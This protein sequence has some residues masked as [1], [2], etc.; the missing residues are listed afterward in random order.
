MPS[1]KQDITAVIERPRRPTFS[2]LSFTS[3]AYLP[4]FCS[5][6]VLPSVRSHYIWPKLLS[7]HSYIISISNN[8][9][10]S[11]PFSPYSYLL[12]PHYTP[13]ISQCLHLQV[14]RMFTMILITFFGQLNQKRWGLSG[15]ILR[16]YYSR[17]AC[18]HACGAVPRTGVDQN[19]E[20]EKE[21]QKHRRCHFLM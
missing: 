2:S 14:K 17:H 15:I 13:V 3:P 8:K 4:S 5:S 18:R 7:T 11:S 1:M 6:F 9:N 19:Y 20:T 12:C 21:Q 10:G 16:K